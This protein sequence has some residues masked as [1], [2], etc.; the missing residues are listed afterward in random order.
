M[1][2]SGIIKW[3]NRQTRGKM[4]NVTSRLERILRLFCSIKKLV[5]DD[6]RDAERLGVIIETFTQTLGTITQDANT[7]V[8]IQKITKHQKLSRSCI[9]G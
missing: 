4:L 2:G 6:V 5:E 7:K 3:Q 8:C 9:P 1:D